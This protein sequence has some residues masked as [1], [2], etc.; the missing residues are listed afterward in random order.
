LGELHKS[1]IN[2]PN[3]HHR[4]GS[5][6]I[7]IFDT[8]PYCTIFRS[9][10][11]LLFGMYLSYGKGFNLAMFEVHKDQTELRAQLDD[12]FNT[13][14]RHP[15]TRFLVRFSHYSNEPSANSRVFIELVNLDVP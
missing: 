14:W 13:L 15:N 10:D 2:L 11:R 6:E 4:I 3:L 8:V 7:R 5:F 9:D 1:K 12:H